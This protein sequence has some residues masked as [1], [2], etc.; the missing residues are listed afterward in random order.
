MT[1]CLLDYP[2]TELHCD[3][4]WEL[5]QQHRRE[6]EALDL[7]RR[8]V[9]AL[10]EANDLKE[11][12]LYKDKDRPKRRPEYPANLPQNSTPVLPRIVRRSL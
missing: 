12:E 6:D 2:H 10:E 11:A 7:L 3:Y 4:H 5:F 8:Q 1:E 9:K